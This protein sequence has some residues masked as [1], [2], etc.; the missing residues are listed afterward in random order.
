MQILLILFGS[1]LIRLISLGQSL[2]LDEATSALV[3]KM[4]FSQMFSNFLPG[5]F[6]PPFYY[7]FLK[8]WSGIFGYSEIA[9]RVPSVIFGVLTIY[10]VYLIG[11]KLFD[12]NTALIASVLLATSGLHIYYSQ[13]AR[14]YALAAFLVSLLV[15]LF[16]EE[17]WIL[18]SVTLIFIGMTDYVSLLILPALWLW[19]IVSKQKNFDWKKFLFSH[20]P[21]AFVFALWLPTFIRQLK[22]GI[23]LS[24]TAPGWW[25]IL[26]Q[27]TV[28]NI[29]LIPVKFMIGR[30][31]IDNKVVYGLAMVVAGAVFLYLILRA[32]KSFFL[33]IWLGVSLILGII[34]SFFIPTLTYFRYLFVLPAF[35]LLISAGIVSLKKPWVMVAIV[36]VLFVNLISSFAY[37]I[38]PRLWREDW[39]SLVIFVESKKTQNSITIFVADSNMEAYKYYAPNAKIAGPEAVKNGYDQIWLMRYVQDVFDPGDITRV[40][41]ES[42]GYKNV[43]EYDF[44]GV[45]VWEYVK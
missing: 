3:A 31:S 37:L 44:N 33:W 42:L 43:G 36:F 18:F 23:G 15:Y 41:V 17:R 38:I 30:V 4:S 10:L 21:F 7:V 25:N 2:W 22:G 8:L 16:L 1:L 5:D 14:M 24:I 11:K 27:V 20:I 6:H 45:V 28:K 32:Q 9:L 26:G 12:K 13:E 39:R 19:A 34:L 40:K 35:Y 29:A